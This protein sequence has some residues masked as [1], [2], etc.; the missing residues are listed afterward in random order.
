MKFGIYI[1]IPHCLQVC[2]YCDFTKYE[3]GKIM[4]PAKYVELLSSEIRLR[5]RDIPLREVNTVYFGGGTPSLFD[6]PLILTILQALAKEGFEIRDDAEITLEINPGTIDQTR[7]TEYMKIGINRFSVGAQTFNER[8]LKVAGRKHSGLETVETLR[9][10]KNNSVNYSFDLL[11]ALPTQ[12]LAEL[13]ADLKTTLAFDPSHLSAYCLTVPEGHS[14][15]K[16]RAP[17][18]EQVEMFDLIEETLAKN[19]ILKYEVSNFAR[20]GFESKHN[21]L[22]WTDQA[23]WGIG[24]SSHSYFPFLANETSRD[25][26][27]TRFS[28]P[29]SLV[30]HEK[31]VLAA[32][33][34]PGD[35][36]FSVRQDLTFTRA[37]QDSQ[38]ER[39]TQNEALTDFCHT[40][41]RLV[42]GLDRNAARLKFGDPIV[43]RLDEI[44]K[45][46]MDEGLVL[47]T[48]RGWALTNRGRLLADLVFSKF[49]FLKGD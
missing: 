22:Y 13:H 15:A 42:S 23:Y 29:P 10:L 40:S 5:A 30:A 6:P 20:P 41:L 37:F 35:E 47:Q 27:G 49:T 4:P 1:H 18:A 21:L 14:M 45:H 38:V 9:L 7:L 39:L 3:F 2:P 31:Q 26:F 32:A 12:T 8:L 48:A 43:S 28:N 24:V 11:F 46:L 34:P 36:P 16:G 19:G 25:I 33:A 44:S 17:E